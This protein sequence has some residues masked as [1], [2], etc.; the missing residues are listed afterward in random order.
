MRSKAVAAGAAL[1]LVAI[2]LTFMLLLGT[3]PKA[4][5]SQQTT[6]SP[7]ASAPSSVTVFI[8]QGAAVNTKDP[9]YSPAKI[10]VVIGVNNTVVW[11]NLDNA[12]HDE[13]ISGLNVK[14]PDLN[15]GD[16]WSYTF[17]APG[18][19]EYVCVYHPWMKG[20]ITVLPAQGS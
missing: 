6:S 10:T 14:S 1:G 15:Y 3:A 13:Y 12:I 7:P 5:S 20:I 9:G 4:P 19:Y 11:K 2:V 16:T 8:K 17:T 18:T